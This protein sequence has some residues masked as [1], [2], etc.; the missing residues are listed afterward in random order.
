VCGHV[1]RDDSAGGD[2]RAMT[3]A[4]AVGDHHGAE[5]DVVFDDDALGADGSTNGVRD[6]QTWSTATIWV[7]GDVCD[8]DG[9]RRPGRAP[10]CTR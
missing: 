8:R 4:C 6:R 7:I 10:P 2:H 9:P 5:P 1:G 3:D